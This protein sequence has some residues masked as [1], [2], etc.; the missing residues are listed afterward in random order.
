MSGRCSR[1]PASI[2]A[3]SRQRSSETSTTRPWPSCSKR[4]TAFARCS[5]RCRMSELLREQQFSLARHLRDPQR[6]APPSGIEAR[7]LKVYRELFYGAIE[8][9]LAGSFPVLRQTLGEPRWHARVHDFYANYR[10][11]TPLFTEIA[12]A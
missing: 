11:Q 12:E 8:G 4:L 7:R 6:H 5:G 1:W 9:L 10:S 3:H 2:L